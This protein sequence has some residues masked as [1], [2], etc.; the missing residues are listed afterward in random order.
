MSRHNLIKTVLFH[1]L[2]FIF[3]LLFSYFHAVRIPHY[4]KEKSKVR[5]IPKE[6][7]MEIKNSNSMTMVTAGESALF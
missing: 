6:F 7:S 3:I 1:F 4:A 5:S 2:F